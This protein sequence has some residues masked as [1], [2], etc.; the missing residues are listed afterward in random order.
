MRSVPIT[1]SPHFVPVYGRGIRSDLLL[2]SFLFSY[3][4]PVSLSTFVYL[5]RITALAC[6]RP[7]GLSAPAFAEHLLSM[8]ITVQR[9]VSSEASSFST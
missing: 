5:P 2:L 6:T 4:I 1:L 7:V 9:S 8:T 3:S